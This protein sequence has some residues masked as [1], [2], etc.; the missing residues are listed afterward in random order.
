[1]AAPEQGIALAHRLL[2]P[3]GRLIVVDLAPHREAWVLDKLGHR[4]LGFAADDLLG[5]LRGTG[6]ADPVLEQ[7]HQRRGEA[8]HVFL[9]T[10]SKPQSGESVLAAADSAAAGPSALT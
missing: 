9:A 3:G 2:R 7:V 5:M 1:M 8:F 6:F 4:H 10:G